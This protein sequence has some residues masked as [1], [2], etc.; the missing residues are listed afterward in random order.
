MNKKVQQL[1]IDD[2]MVSVH[3]QDVT[4]VGLKWVRRK[5]TVQREELSDLRQ[6]TLPQ[7][8]CHSHLKI[9][10]GNAPYDLLKATSD[11]FATLGKQ[12]SA[13]DLTMRW[14]EH[15]SGLTY[16]HLHF[17]LW[18]HEGLQQFLSVLKQLEY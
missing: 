6:E 18:H 17:A 11:L 8:Q 7:L 3:Q 14:G 2:K 15:Y 1:F 5:P 13:T 12:H 4:P 9:I 16:N 10:P